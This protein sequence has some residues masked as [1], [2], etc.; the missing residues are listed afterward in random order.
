MRPLAPSTGVRGCTLARVL[1]VQQTA[2]QTV[3]CRL[4]R[5]PPR[6]K[7]LR[8]VLLYTC[9]HW[10]RLAG[11]DDK[12]VARLEQSL[13]L[14]PHLRPALRLMADIHLQRGEL[15][16]A[17]TYLDEEI[18]CTQHPG[19]AGALYRERGRLLQR[20]DRDLD[21]ASQC[22][23]AALHAAPK[24]WASL[25]S[26]TQH[27]A[28]I[29]DHTAL[30]AS[31]AQQL[32]ALDDP[33][34]AASV[35]RELAALH[36]GPGGD[37][38]SA[39]RHL[40]AALSMIPTHAGLLAD[41]E[42]VAE[43][44]GDHDFLIE[45]LE[46]SAIPAGPASTAALARLCLLLPDN[47]PSPTTLK[48]F[49]AYAHA[50]P[51]V[52]S[53]WHLLT[54]QA[55]R[56]GDYA[57][58]VEGLG[59]ALDCME[60]DDAPGRAQV[61]YRL[62][63]LS[64]EHLDRVEDGLAF[65]RKAL[66]CDPTHR[67][68]YLD[69]AELLEAR[70]DWG[71]L[72]ELVRQQAEL[73]D[74][75]ERGPETVADAYTRAAAI[76]L[77]RLG[78]APRARELI[79]RAQSVAP[80]YRP[81][82]D[83]M[84]VILRA[85]GTRQPLT[86]LYEDELAEA[87]HP[88]RK[89]SILAQLARIALDERDPSRALGHLAKLLQHERHHGPS[90]QLAVWIMTHSAGHVRPRLR[91]TL[92]ELAHAPTP[93]RRAFLSHRAGQI[94]TSEGNVEDAITH[95]CSAI[96]AEDDHLG[97]IAE[98]D[99]L[100]RET[101][102]RTARLTLLAKRV[103][104]TNCRNEQVYCHLERAMIMA[105]HS[106]ER[107][108]AIDEVDAVLATVPK[109]PI[110]LYLAQD[111]AASA[112]NWPRHVQLL[113]DRLSLASRPKARAV[114]QLAA[115]C[116]YRYHLHDPDAAFTALEQAFQSDGTLSVVCQCLAEAYFRRG[117]M[118]RLASLTDGNPDLQGILPHVWAAPPTVQS[119]ET[120]I[121]S[122][123][124]LRLAVANETGDTVIHRR[125]LKGLR[126]AGNYEEYAE[127]ATRFVDRLERATVPA[128]QR[129]RFM[130]LAAR[131]AEAAGA[132]VVAKRLC[133]ATLSLDPK[134]GAAT[135]AR[136]RID[137]SCPRTASACRT[138]AGS[139]SEGL[140]AALRDRIADAT[141]THAI[142]DA[143]VEL[144]I[145]F[146][147][148][149]NF[150]AA[151]A[152]YARALEFAE[153]HP[154]ARALLAETPDN[155]TPVPQL[156]ATLKGWLAEPL[157][158]ALRGALLYELARCQPEATARATLAEAARI[159]PKQ[160]TLLWAAILATD[161]L[162]D[163][164]AAARHYASLAQVTEHAP[165]RGLW[166]VCSLLAAGHAAVPPPSATR[167][168]LAVAANDALLYETL[169]A[170]A[171]L[172][173]MID[174][175]LDRAFGPEHPR[176]AELTRNVE[177]ALESASQSVVIRER[178]ARRR[179][180][181]TRPDA[182]LP[183]P[184][185]APRAIAD[186]EGDLRYVR[187]HLGSYVWAHRHLARLYSERDDRASLVDTLRGWAGQVEGAEAGLIYDRLGYALL[188]NN[189]PTQ[190]A[191]AFER[192]VG[193]RPDEF[194]YVSRLAQAYVGDN[195][196]KD[197]VLLLTRYANMADDPAMRA[198]ALREAGWLAG[199]DLNCNT[200][201]T[202]S[203]EQLVVLE[204]HD[205]AASF[206]VVERLRDEGTPQRRMTCLTQLVEHLSDPIARTPL[207]VELAVLQLDDALD[208]QAG[209]R[210]LRRALDLTPGYAPAL[211]ALD[212]ALRR[213]D[214][215]AARLE[216]CDPEYDP[217]TDPLTLA[218]RGA[219]IA[220]N[221]IGDTDRCAVYLEA[222]YDA[223]PYND[224]GRNELLGKLVWKGGSER[225][226]AILSAHDPDGGVAAEAD[227]HYQLGVRALACSNDEKPDPALAIEALDHFRA[228]IAIQPEH[229]L[230]FI[231][232]EKLLIKHGDDT[233]LIA[234]LETAAEAFEGA[235]LVRTLVQL[236]RL[237]ARLGSDD[238]K[239]RELY[240]RAYRLAPGDRL[241][242]HEFEY[243]ARQHGEHTLVA[244]LVCERA[245][246]TQDQAYA[247]ALYLEAA[248]C[249]LE[250]GNSAHTSRA[251]TAVL[252]ALRLIPGEPHCLRHLDRLLDDAEP[253]MD[254]C[255][256]V[257]ARALR[258]Q[259]PAEHAVFCME[260][261]EL[262]ERAG[263]T[264]EA[265]GAYGAA[266]SALP[267]LL[268]AEMA[269][270]R[271]DDGAQVPFLHSVD[272]D[273]IPE[274][275]TSDRPPSKRASDTSL[276]E[277]MDLA[278]DAFIRLGSQASDHEAEAAL[279]PLRAVLEADPDH[280]DALSLTRAVSERVA[281]RS[282]AMSVLATAFPLLT[283]DPLRHDIGL[284]LAEFHGPGSTSTAFLTAALAAQPESTRA[285]LAQVHCHQ[286]TGEDDEAIATA[287]RMLRIL[288]SAKPQVVD[289][290]LRLVRVLGGADTTRT[291]ALSQ[292]DQL[293]AT[294]PDDAR[295][296]L[297]KAELCDQD[298]RLQEAIALLEGLASRT[299]DPTQLHD[300]LVDQVELLIRSGDT[301]SQAQAAIER[302]TELQPGNTRT[303]R[304]LIEILE[305]NGH[306]ARFG[307]FLPQMHAALLNRIEQGALDVGDIA[308]LERLAQPIDPALAH[309]AAVAHFAFEPSRQPPPGSGR[310]AATKRLQRMLSGREFESRLLAA[311][312]PAPLHRLIKVCDELLGGLLAEFSV[313]G[314]T[315]AVALP[316][317]SA[318]NRIRSVVHAW[319]E[320]AGASRLPLLA[321]KT[322]QTA[323][324]LP[325]DAPALHVSED[326]WLKGD[327]AAWRGLS[328]IAIARWL[329]CPSGIRSLPQPELTAW[330][331]A[332][333]ECADVAHAIR[334]QADPE[335][336]AGL[337]SSLTKT[338]TRRKR[339]SLA[340]ACKAAAHIPIVP[341][342]VARATLATDLRLATL[343]TGRLGD[344][345]YAAALLDGQ[346]LGPLVQR[347]R[348]STAARSLLVFGLRSDMIEL[349]RL[350][351]DEA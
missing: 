11:E 333:F 162:D 167:D 82:R 277:L 14:M 132:C 118:S 241:L 84:P 137:A 210:S 78:D 315:D 261:G 327:V 16:A 116:T 345:L 99:D 266:R 265:R 244:E 124:R 220:A 225:A 336:V 158:P 133:V 29:G 131:A 136:Q 214:D 96:E 231:S 39:G 128:T 257:S 293:I 81:T 48:L 41:L 59:G 90:N 211:R 306:E 25:R 245:K 340:A 334:D 328:A 74:P 174:R 52:L 272:A 40:L 247:A 209:E 102:A 263:A 80:H 217:L 219:K 178:L 171:A 249:S 317:H 93:G 32:A 313:L 337:V 239:V 335:R 127:M 138:A 224:S 205:W 342:A 4:Q 238:D 135:E 57:T 24:D 255:R 19:E 156:A 237:H 1:A 98:L 256:A 92:A 18:R 147:A 33:Q 122:L 23:R 259:S 187:L 123:P 144:G 348:D 117:E 309:A 46:R 103:L 301:G 166:A 298:G 191:A 105:D 221:H 196:R 295:A 289:D 189:A 332:C 192:A 87:D 322:Q 113:E 208:S 31:L 279:T 104:Y 212:R 66:R 6:E 276:H 126:A 71:A 229:D 44:S 143:W 94:A 330:L 152:A 207:L 179:I 139:E 26:L 331:T 302:A 270:R 35:L 125:L 242:L 203:L 64:L 197:A 190:A 329:V 351:R 240:N 248:E 100:Y 269:L 60:S 30:E 226:Y 168:V 213:R 145:A 223:D 222:A 106:A 172:P 161:D 153:R 198:A 252:D 173:G 134:F 194:A 311:G 68:A 254:V 56:R 294:H 271:L 350:V 114:L 15:R 346:H 157:A 341:E 326:L 76:H 62:A 183:A 290:R 17:I 2:L 151:A 111:L 307:R 281:D 129:A 300:L 140:F 200:L 186:L 175:T 75:A 55:V 193:Y 45:A 232:A 101:H 308:L 233:N 299:Q 201:R 319:L 304:R 61:Y 37:L 83:L 49:T 121:A 206:D 349:R 36:T 97:A 85:L 28:G 176:V 202:D 21:P 169:P 149:E 274:Q 115:A 13:E 27:A 236:A 318:P 312:E 188:A 251:A 253:S 285:L 218:L 282:T 142:A 177:Q 215:P 50:R 20:H 180:D 316:V 91:L 7:P 234:L 292:I 163:A 227:Y 195:R 9:A 70:Q 164:P 258:A 165:A 54:D 216:L 288:V 273:A 284:L 264:E 268:V 72:A 267:G 146:D 339:R 110:A 5:V 325:G 88:A 347:V 43:H 323:L 65:L 296:V 107:D 321:C 42:R 275:P 86:A 3:L 303:L 338:I 160:P 182:T 344:C 159:D 130:F 228:A 69:L 230:A 184:S 280:H 112:Q 63:R 262:L 246:R 47:D 286:Q 22:Y 243:W 148:A 287:E 343:L 73:A 283:Q 12:A 58:A 95:F 34:S 51:S 199:T 53:G 310:V 314:G 150:G 77:H 235:M 120:L 260:S 141:G 291:A 154:V 38:A 185:S 324:L 119:D 79:E 108:A 170:L 8:A 10:H 181:A 278:R 297:L 204:P 250:S 320:A 155:G 67:V 305:A 89:T 109:H